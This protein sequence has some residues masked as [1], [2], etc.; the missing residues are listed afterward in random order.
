M[1]E[2]DE[3]MRR[4]LFSVVLGS[5]FLAAGPSARADE[6][7]RALFILGIHMSGAEGVALQFVGDPTNLKPGAIGLMKRTLR[8]SIDVADA[9]KL[10]SDGLKSLLD[11]VNRD[12]ETF[13]GMTARMATLRLDMQANA[14]KSINPG[15]AAFFIMGV[16]QGGAERVAIG[17]EGFRRQDKPGT[18]ALIERQLLRLADGTS[19][20]KLSLKPVLDIQDNL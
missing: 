15:A 2:G 14:A 11:D 3:N 19:T 4:V 12:R 18:G 17:G 16:D 13:A 20:T 8:D 7:K 6:I 10:P 1:S 9:L 5:C